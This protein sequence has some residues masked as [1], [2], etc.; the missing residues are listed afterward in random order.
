MKPYFSI[1]TLFFTIISVVAISCGGEAT[2]QTQTPETANTLDYAEFLERTSDPRHGE[3]ALSNFQ[4]ALEI[5]KSHPESDPLDI[6]ITHDQIALTH[7]GMG[8]LDDSISHYLESLGIRQ[9]TPNA[10]NVLLAASHDNVAKIYSVQ[11]W[12]DKALHHRLAALQRRTGPPAGSPSDIAVSHHNIAVLYSILDRNKEAL[13]YFLNALRLWLQIPET[14]PSDL[15][16]SYDDTAESL[17]KL[18]RD[19][20]ALP[21]YQ[22]ALEIRQ[23][24]SS[25][26]RLGIA[27]SHD[28]LA[29]TFYRLDR[30]E[31]A[32]AEY[33]NSLGIRQADPNG[34]PLELAKSYDNVANLYFQM[35]LF[36]DALPHYQESLTILE[37]L[38]D[39]SSDNLATAHEN[40]AGVYQHTYATNHALPHYQSAVKIRK[41]SSD[42]D[43][44]RL[45]VTLTELGQT[46]RYQGRYGEALAIFQEALD[47]V[48]NLHRADSPEIATALNNIADILISI[49]D[50]EEA[51]FLLEQALEILEMSPETEPLDLA[52]ARNS[53]A[54]LMVRMGKD[55][56]SL[57]LF[58]SVLEIL[59][60]DDNT[61]P[62]DLARV[63]NNV[64]VLYSS[65]DKNEK[66]LELYEEV[67]AIRDAI[68]PE[69]H[70][71]LAQTLYNQAAVL[72]RMEDYHRAIDLA[73]QS[74]E[75]WTQ[76]LGYNHPTTGKALNLL[77]MLYE[78]EGNYSKALELFSDSLIA[79][80]Q[81]FNNIFTVASEQQK[82][83]FAQANQGSYQAALSLIQR[84]FD[85]DE[86]AARFGLELVL[87]RKGIVL[88]AQAQAQLALTQNLEGESLES[89]QRLNQLRGELANRLLLGPGIQNADEYR[90]EIQASEDEI[91]RVDQKLSQLVGKRSGGFDLA[92]INADQLAAALPDDGV[93]IEYVRMNDWDEKHRT[94][95]G[96]TRYVAFSLTSENRVHMADLGDAKTIDDLVK[97]TLQV[98]G[99]PFKE[100]PVA[101]NKATDA[102]LSDLHRLLLQ[103]LGS[104][105]TDSDIL[106]L[107]PDGE[108]N[109]APFAALISDDGRYL[110]ESHTISYVASGRDILRDFLDAK[111]PST[112]N[113]DLF[114]VANPTYDFFDPLTAAVDSGNTFRKADLSLEFNP[115]PG[116]G[117]E[118]KLIPPLIGGI[119]TV[120]QDAEATELEIKSINPPNILHL[121]THGFFLEDNTLPLPSLFAR[122]EPVGDR[123]RGIGGVKSTLTV[124][125]ATEL[126]PGVELDPMVRS[127]LALAGANHPG[128]APGG[129]DGILTALEVS[130]MNL[131]GTKLVVLS[132]CET[133]IGQVS[134][135]EGV[136][137]LRR[138][139]TL[140]GS[141]NLVMSLWLV[142]D[143][144]TVLQMQEFYEE[145]GQDGSAANSLHEAQLATIMLLR[146]FYSDY[147]QPMAPVK[148]WAP[149]IAQQATGFNP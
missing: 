87:R 62:L 52:T 21:Y 36:E 35:D 122:S 17:V 60:Q 20:E 111:T 83:L 22:N 81:S 110:I 141:Q 13:E 134:N 138:A 90:E 145:F 123:T 1:L 27:N 73:E 96:T 117:R 5:R 43:L 144:F 38:P 66:A 61:E 113:T 70:H 11:E 33:N 126:P 92:S 37:A 34:A 3:Q 40:L 54:A 109:K 14:A 82:L 58:E 7:E 4:A 101:Y 130:G 32:L 47:Q 112:H 115:L 120:L 129:N 16:A 8:N 85:E 104:I 72:N 140:A 15:A 75:I 64:A 124:S 142:D 71:E 48:E 9:E 146:D 76:A 114:L 127:G 55:G 41:E 59:E 86:D 24:E 10:S 93:L 137:G 31:E 77:G 97:E 79:E 18:N 84:H 23:K 30:F 102:V 139:F 95:A 118:A 147:D 132:A 12:Y 63:K 2:S 67:Q 105:V 50:F 91:D 49:G 133:A 74:L 94:W 121:A 45:A 135:G 29:G 89:W 128:S 107:S 103:P 51:S 149:F 98:I 26:D 6:A 143:D 108:V 116:T 25:I 65:A 136:F 100:D 106:L 56:Q 57:K 80:D 88:D 99:R 69:G 19:E 78:A 28:N 46:Y 39:V 68:L 53:M 44:A 42:P 125:P 119:Q 148:I 131:Q